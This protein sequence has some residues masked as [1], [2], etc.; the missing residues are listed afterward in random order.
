MTKPTKWPV[1]PVKTQIKRGICAV[2]LESSLCTQWVAKGVFRW[3]AKTLIRLGGCPGWSVSSL[4]AQAILLI[5]SC[6]GWNLTL[7]FPMIF[8]F[9]VCRKGRGSSGGLLSMAQYDPWNYENSEYRNDPK[10]SDRQAWA[11]SAVPDP[12]RV[13]TVCHSICIIW[14]HYSTVKPLF[15]NFR[16]ITANFSGVRIFRNFENSERHKI[17]KYLDEKSV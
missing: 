8:L 12:T 13:F 6:C 15:F 1:H 17:T 7:S 11:N 16:V 5:L 14:T 10:F 9:R 4:G 3:T 2:W